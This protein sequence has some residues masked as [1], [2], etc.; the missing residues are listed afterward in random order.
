MNNLPNGTRTP[1]SAITSIEA[2]WA[3]CSDVGEVEGSKGDRGVSLEVEGRPEY[4]LRGGLPELVLACETRETAGACNVL[5]ERR[6]FD[7]DFLPCWYS[8]DEISGE[9]DGTITLN[10]GA[11]ESV[12]ADES[13]LEETSEG[14]SVVARRFRERS[15]A[16][17]ELGGDGVALM[18]DVGDIDLGSQ[19]DGV[20]VRELKVGAGEIE[21]SLAASTSAGKAILFWPVFDVGNWGKFKRLLPGL[22]EGVASKANWGL[23][24]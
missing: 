18:D 16:M 2:A 17:I 9:G 6:G 12:D 23:E 7:R 15:V 14:V 5:P 1:L 13:D 4:R 21:P 8:E 19:R 10:T 3:S 20:T 22:A 11:D 24:L